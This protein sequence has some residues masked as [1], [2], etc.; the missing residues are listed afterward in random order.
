MILASQKPEE[1]TYSLEI[2]LPA[3]NLYERADMING[4]RANAPP[5]MFQALLKIAERVLDPY[6]WTA[7]KPKIGIK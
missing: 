2:M 7:L 4:G 5:E 6:D 1:Q 3:I